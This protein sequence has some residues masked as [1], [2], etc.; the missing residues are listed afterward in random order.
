MCATAMRAV[1][2]P[3]AVIITAEGTVAGRTTGTN[4]H[5]AMTGPDMIGADTGAVGTTGITGTITTGILRAA[6]IPALF[7]V[8]EPSEKTVK[9][10]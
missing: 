7:P 9:I 3:I 4:M 6:G 5:A 2:R 8:R 10:T 1:G